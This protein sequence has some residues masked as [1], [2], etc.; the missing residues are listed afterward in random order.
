MQGQY[1]YIWKRCTSLQKMRLLPTPL[2]DFLSPFKHPTLPPPPPPL[3][4][5][6]RPRPPSPPSLPLPPSSSSSLLVRLPSSP[7]PLFLLFISLYC[8][9]FRDFA[10][11][12][13]IR[14]T[15]K[16]AYC[17]R[18]TGQNQ[19]YRTFLRKLQG[20]GSTASYNTLF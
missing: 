10:S 20:K 3:H 2:H 12:I 4:S 5:P 1:C 16:D 6:P 7:F 13:A 15:S 11:S 8:S 19:V 9:Y 14:N 18:Q 17:S